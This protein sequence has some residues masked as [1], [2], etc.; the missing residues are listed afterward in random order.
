M[1][2]PNASTAWR[3]APLASDNDQ[4]ALRLTFT[5][6]GQGAESRHLDQVV[7]PREGSGFDEGLNRYREIAVRH[8]G[9]MTITSVPGESTTI[10]L[11][12]PLP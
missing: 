3:S 4:E 10:T 2:V 1:A 6:H 9:T 8:G 11:E 12:F 7:E 5:D